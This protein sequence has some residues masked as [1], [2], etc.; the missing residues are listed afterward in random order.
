MNYTFEKP[1][2]PFTV[3]RVRGQNV[4]RGSGL[5]FSDQTSPAEEGWDITK[6]SVIPVPPEG[7]QCVDTIAWWEHDVY[8]E[9]ILGLLAQRKYLRLKRRLRV[10]ELRKMYLNLLKETCTYSVSR[11]KIV[12]W[13]WH[14][15]VWYQKEWAWRTVRIPLI[16]YFTEHVYVR[17]YFEKSRSTHRIRKRIRVKKIIGFKTKKE[18]RYEKVRH[19]EWI[20]LPVWETWSEEHT[21]WKTIRARLRDQFPLLYH[22][23]EA[24][25]RLTIELDI[26]NAR[27]GDRRAAKRK[28]PC[29]AKGM[30][31]GSY[32][33][34]YQPLS[35]KVTLG[36]HDPQ[37]NMLLVRSNS[38]PI[39]PGAYPGFVASY[40]ADA[41]KELLSI[42][43][44]GA[45]TT[46]EV[47]NHWVVSAETRPTEKWDEL[48]KRITEGALALM[49][50]DVNITEDGAFVGARSVLELK[51]LPASAKQGRDFLRFIRRMPRMK[52]LA[53]LGK[54]LGSAA[55]AY[56]AYKFAI[57]PTSQDV[58]AVIKNGW[59]YLSTLRRGLSKI[60]DRVDPYLSDDSAPIHL[61]RMVAKRSL[62]PYSGRSWTPPAPKTKV[63]TLGNYG[64]I[65][66]RLPMEWFY[67]DGGGNSVIAPIP[68][69]GLGVEPYFNPQYGRGFSSRDELLA[70][71]RMSAVDNIALAKREM[72]SRAEDFCDDFIVTDTRLSALLFAHI[73][74]SD[75][76]AIF[77][78]DSWASFLERTRLLQTM[79]ELTPL[80]FVVDW[81]AT[82]NNVARALQ[83][84]AGVWT[85]GL[86]ISD[87][88]WWCS[89]NADVFA[90]QS[91]CEYVEYLTSYLQVPFYGDEYQ[92]ATV[93]RTQV[94][95]RKPISQFNYTGCSK[96][97]RWSPQ[98]FNPAGR[99]FL[100]SVKIHADESKLLTLGLMI[101]PS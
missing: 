58:R 43:R 90:A 65:H 26:L 88:T 9:E 81:F 100:P 38:G 56:L 89:L 35:T 72:K 62:K 21:D 66:E 86:N 12:D 3:P 75:A 44:S 70:S 14:H 25:Q 42:L 27:I 23:D 13:R 32:K 71:F 28:L 57:E 33:R 74:T 5:I 63:T 84:L 40:G 22:D 16:K 61:R 10:A 2:G 91:Q 11:K 69:D 46:M 6:T 93:K 47:S 55:K 73:T 8:S 51:D 98:G 24:Y 36:W 34:S 59:E 29:P 96:Y 45:D 1:L 97:Q 39:P 19:E 82:T 77:L 60:V 41:S 17:Q 7:A 48:G 80:S 87:L 31:Q 92:L 20:R 30:T 79:W 37:W 53:I 64:Y 68:I 101:T 18:W 4:L 85:M 78:R 76:R 49:N 94:C 15:P 67:P 99:E 83:N 50:G 95:I 54:T 52:K